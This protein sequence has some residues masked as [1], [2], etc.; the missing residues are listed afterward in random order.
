[1]SSIMKKYLPSSHDILYGQYNSSQEN[2]AEEIERIHKKYGIFP[3]QNEY[4]PLSVYIKEADVLFNITLDKKI[5]IINDAVSKKGHRV[6]KDW[7]GEDWDYRAE[8]MGDDSKQEPTRVMIKH[9]QTY[10][11]NL[12][13]YTRD[14]AHSTTMKEADNFM[15]EATNY[16]EKFHDLEVECNGCLAKF[17]DS[18]GNP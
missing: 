7:I 3:H 6:K 8:I 16:H 15:L 10:K 14:I 12:E 2:A 4:N 13:K 9:I 17:E 1:M 5:Q 11:E 18:L